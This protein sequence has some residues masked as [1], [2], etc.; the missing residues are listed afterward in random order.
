MPGW[1]RLAT[2]LGKVG[3][4][5]VGVEATGGYERGV[6]AHL[7]AAAG[8]IVLV[9]QSM[10]VR[11]FAR[12]HLRRAKN[13]ALDAALIAACAATIDQPRIEPDARWDKKASRALKAKMEMQPNSLPQHRAWYP[14]KWLFSA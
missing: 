3:V 1:R 8:F 13:D 4:V 9:L 5:R 2:D 6:V 14:P 11:A 10:Q 12:V 7:R